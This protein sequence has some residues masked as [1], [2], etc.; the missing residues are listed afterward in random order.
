MAMSSQD[1]ER[2]VAALEAQA[3]QQ[4][5]QSSDQGAQLQAFLQGA[6]IAYTASQQSQS[7]GLAAG[8]RGPS[9]QGIFGWNPTSYDSFFWCRSRFMCNPQSL[10]CL[11]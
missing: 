7:T 2:R 8:G 11:C 1:L 6:L 3:G 10:S 9:A 4:G 5:G